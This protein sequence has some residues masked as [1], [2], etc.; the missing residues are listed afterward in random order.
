[1]SNNKKG[2]EV[3]PVWTCRPF[4]CSHTFDCWPAQPLICREVLYVSDRSTESHYQRGHPKNKGAEKVGEIVVDFTFLRKEGLIQ[5]VDGYCRRGKRVGK[6]HYRVT[7][8][9]VIKV[10]D[11]DLQCESLSTQVPRRR[12][13]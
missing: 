7:Y 10:V 13:Y 11:R 5:P 4:L 2:Q 9:M 1:M 12:T 6:R 3:E 8:T